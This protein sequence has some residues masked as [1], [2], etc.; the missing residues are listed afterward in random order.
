MDHHTLNLVFSTVMT[1][2]WMK[3]KMMMIMMRT[4]K[5]E[6]EDVD[7]YVPRA[8]LKNFP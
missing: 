7:N 5:K 1:N 3:M 8:I 4:K 2:A 6:E